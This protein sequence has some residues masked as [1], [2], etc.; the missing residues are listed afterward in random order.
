MVT[1]SAWGLVK[2]ILGEAA[3]WQTVVVP[4][5]VAVGVGRTVT[6]TSNRNVLSQTPDIWL[7]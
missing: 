1:A 2:V 6:V 4:L 7:A 3:F 5:M